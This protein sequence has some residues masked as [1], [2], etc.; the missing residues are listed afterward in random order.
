MQITTGTTFE[1]FGSVDLQRRKIGM[2]TAPGPNS[3]LTNSADLP[4]GW[5]FDLTTKFYI[6]TETT[7]QPHMDCTVRSFSIWYSYMEGSN[8]QQYL[9]G[10]SSN[11]KLNLLY[12]DSISFV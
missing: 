11:F 1:Y 12:F 10:L 3:V 4:D 6:C 9:W 8:A 5:Q 7:G 2:I